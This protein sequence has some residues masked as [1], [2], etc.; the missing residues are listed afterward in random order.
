MFR[1][2]HS[3]SHPP[4]HSLPNPPSL[5][6]RPRF[7]WPVLSTENIS[8]L[9]SL[10]VCVSVWVCVCPWQTMCSCSCICVWL[11]VVYLYL[12]ILYLRANVAT[13]WQQ[14]LLPFYINSINVF[15]VVRSSCSC[16]CSHCCHCCS[17]CCSCSCCCCSGCC[18]CCCILK[19]N[20]DKCLQET[21]V[22]VVEHFAYFHKHIPSTATECVAVYVCVCALTTCCVYWYMCVYYLTTSSEN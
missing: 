19:V 14:L 20:R 22:E 11:C 8:C 18:C 4:S 6:F 3:H 5:F 9:F 12:C 17:C 10:D 7:T 15:V 16:S 2:E 13:I 1:L 21:F